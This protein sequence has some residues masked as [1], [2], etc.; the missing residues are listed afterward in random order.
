MRRSICLLFIICAVQVFASSAY[1]HIN[2]QG[3]I[4]WTNDGRSHTDHIEMSGKRVSVVLRYG[5]TSAGTFTCNFGMVWPMLRTVPNNT[6]A[7]LMRQLQW[8][9]LDNVT[10]NLRSLNG[11]NVDSIMLDGTLTVQSHFGKIA[12]RRIIT[13]STDLPAVVE[14]ITM[15]NGGQRA[16]K[17]NDR[18]QR[19]E[20]HHR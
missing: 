8:N 2:H 6:Y 18:Q 15:T 12:V 16:V 10:V 11:E 9:A 17:V 4:T 5:I 19:E 7:S 1:W 14:Q 13:P 20:H 3:G